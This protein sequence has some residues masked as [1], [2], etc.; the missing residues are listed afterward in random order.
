MAKAPN[1]T[2]AN[3]NDDATQQGEPGTTADTQVE[4][5]D[6]QKAAQERQ[7]M[8]DSDSDE[9]KALAYP[10]NEQ[11]AAIANPTIISDKQADAVLHDFGHRQGYVA[12]PR[13]GDAVVASELGYQQT[14]GGI[15]RVQLQAKRNEDENYLDNK[16]S[17]EQGGEQ[18]IA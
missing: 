4:L 15:A 5:T 12:A 17:A 2:D 6:E 18:K 16:L 7:N 8:L 13:E 9:A 10:T 3:K 14:S 11:D 1:K